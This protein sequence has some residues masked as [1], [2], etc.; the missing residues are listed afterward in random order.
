MKK[1]TVMVLT[2][3]MMLLS[4]VPVFADEVIIDDKAPTIAIEAED[5]TSADTNPE[6]LAED[7]VVNPTEDLNDISREDTEDKSNGD[8]GDQKEDSV[9]VPY[10]DSESDSLPDDSEGLMY[11][12]AGASSIP[13]SSISLNKAKVKLNRGDAVQLKATVS[14]KNASN[15]T[16]K[17][18]S[19]S[20]YVTVSNDGY[21]KVWAEGEA[22]ITA[23]AHNGKKATCKI[24]ATLKEPDIQRVENSPKG[25][26]ITIED[27]PE[28][29]S[30][31]IERS[32][33]G[34]NYEP[35]GGCGGNGGGSRPVILDWEPV[36]PTFIDTAVEE[37]VK[38]WY[39]ANYLT[40]WGHTSG[41]GKALS[42]VYKPTVTEP[43]KISVKPSKINATVGDAPMRLNINISPAKAQSDVKYKSSNKKVVKV[44]KTG[45]MTFVGK[46]KANIT[47]TTA[48]GLSAVCKITVKN[49]IKVTSIELNK[50][51]A[52]IKL[53]KSMILQASVLPA[54]AYDKYVFWDVNNENVHMEDMYEEPMEDYKHG[55]HTNRIRIVGDKPWKSIVT[56]E[57][58]DGEKITQCEVTVTAPSVKSL[59]LNKSKLTLSKGEKY[60]LKAKVTPKG[61]YKKVK[62]SSS[63]KKVVS[64]NS[65]GKV[66]AKKKG[67]ATITAKTYDGK[68]K[69]KCKITV[70]GSEPVKVTGVS[71]NKSSVSIIKDNS[72][73]L[74]ATV[75][76]SDATNKNVTWK[77]SDPSV[78]SVDPRGKVMGL[79]E[80]TTS[81]TA[82]TEDGNKEV[83]C[84]VTVEDL[85]WIAY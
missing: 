7:L 65:K 44:S 22:T 46:G 71:L 52:S 77:S 19:N 35:I 8:I 81:I 24:I 49:P 85:K 34:K 40:D 78:A 70:K 15:K 67:T 82:T 47:V 61:A 66:V 13:V 51:S 50:S 17:W 4:S 55:E 48:N 60:T 83:S 23:T 36:V 76:P 27:V 30:Y 1:R 3:L 33:D 58:F 56:A 18:K 74:K 20:D 42:I 16:I 45:M 32:T 73:T 31:T 26:K 10:T 72:I 28:A 2:T 6:D 84:T 79:T 43:S 14:P 9:S 39:R 37:G 38:Y 11:D 59:S 62:W 75:K 63:N 29:M 12:T 5:I 57:T 64:V 80:G 69:A 21:V 54:N 25:I 53:G 68:K 41:N